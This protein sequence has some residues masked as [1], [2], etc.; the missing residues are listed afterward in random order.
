MSKAG[1]ERTMLKQDSPNL[2]SI[3]YRI[4]EL[5]QKKGLTQMELGN[6]IGCA[7]NTITAWEKNKGRAPHKELLGKIAKILGVSVDYL[8]GIGDPNMPRIPCYGEVCTN[9]FAWPENEQPDHYI[10]VPSEEYSTKRYSFKILDDLLEPVIDKGDYGVFEATPVEDGDVVVVYFPKTNKAM[11]KKWRQ[12]N[13]LVM[14]SE[15]NPNNTYPPYF[16]ELKATEGPLEYTIKKNRIN[17]HLIIKGKLVAVKQVAK[18]IK[19]SHK[20]SYIFS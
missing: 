18:S 5:R 17:E 9:E 3:G 2:N 10:E 19:I 14:I 11:I 4:R 16:F 7:Q 1:I 12:E 13:N 6:L 8:F 15:I 20:I